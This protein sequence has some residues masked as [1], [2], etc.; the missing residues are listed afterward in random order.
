MVEIILSLASQPLAIA[1]HCFLPQEARV[2]GIS[3]FKFIE[4]KKENLLD[5]P[6]RRITHRVHQTRKTR[7]MERNFQEN[8]L[9]FQQDYLQVT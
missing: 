7:K 9:Y 6:R 4:S 1:H 3:I 8:V 5:A 2:F